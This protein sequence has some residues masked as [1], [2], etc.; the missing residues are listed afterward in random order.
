MSTISAFR[1]RLNLVRNASS[2]T[3]VARYAEIA[4]QFLATCQTFK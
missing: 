1:R 4:C 2:V 3:K